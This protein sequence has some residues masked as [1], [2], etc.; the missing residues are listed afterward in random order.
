M[1]EQVKGELKDTRS[2]LEGTNAGLTLDRGLRFE[3]PY[4]HPERFNW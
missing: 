4:L 1:L 2:E 3:V